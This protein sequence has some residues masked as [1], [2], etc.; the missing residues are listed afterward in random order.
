MLQTGHWEDSVHKCCSEVR[1][2]LMLALE[3]DNL[4]MLFLSSL[5]LARLA[6]ESFLVSEQILFPSATT[7]GLLA[8]P[9]RKCL[10]HTHMG[11]P[12]AIQTLLA[13][14]IIYQWHWESGVVIYEGLYCS[15]SCIH[16]ST[17]HWASCSADN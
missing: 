1:V 17:Y 15:C 13:K 2:T 5:T 12:H 16:N 8:S 6:C 7:G 14:A 3:C 4:E 10:E 9:S 11:L